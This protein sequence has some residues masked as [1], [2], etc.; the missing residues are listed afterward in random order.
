MASNRHTLF[1]MATTPAGASAAVSPAGSPSMSR[2]GTAST[3]ASGTHLHHRSNSIGSVS[4]TGSAAGHHR[5]AS[6][7]QS[8]Q[9][10]GDAS[11][12]D[13]PGHFSR[14]P[15]VLS[16]SLPLLPRGSSPLASSDAY[17]RGG[18]LPDINTG[19]K[20][21][22]IPSTVRGSSPT[23]RLSSSS[24]R[25]ARKTAMAPSPKL[26]SVGPH[27]SSAPSAVTNPRHD[28]HAGLPVPNWG[29]RAGK[30][31]PFGQVDNEV[32]SVNAD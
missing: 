9:A 32:C 7:S 28:V 30:K 13:A 8:P 5:S 22:S 23:M 17:L 26:A 25:M 20:S 3:R 19:A 6:F 31:L 2:L 18:G 24:L 11:L 27:R 12:E 10:H 4:S 16:S 15:D 1:S 21:T 29:G 14:G